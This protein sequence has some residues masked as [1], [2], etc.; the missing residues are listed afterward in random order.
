MSA[1]LNVFF[2]IEVALQLL[3]PG[4]ATKW[5]GLAAGY[6]HSLS[7][8]A[9]QPADLGFFGGC[10]PVVSGSLPERGSVAR[11]HV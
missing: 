5:P 8:E 2:V 7:L 3:V 9:R 4:N 10:F 6:S 11:L 1:V